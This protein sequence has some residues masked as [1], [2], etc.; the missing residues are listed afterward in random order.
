MGTVAS[1]AIRDPAEGVV[2]ADAA[3]GLVEP[4][5]RPVVIVACPVILP[6]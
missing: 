2:R 3:E 1:Q 6:A 4:C 5:V